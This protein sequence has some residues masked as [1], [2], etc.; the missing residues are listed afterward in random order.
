MSKLSVLVAGGVGYVL[1]ARAG[2]QR[3]E[4]IRS[5]ALRVKGN[6]TVQHTASTAAGAA[7]DAAKHAAP[8]VKDTVTG[9]AGAAVS[10]VK[11]SDSPEVPLEDSAY[12]HGAPPPGSHP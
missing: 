8:V 6:P 10:K 4:Q 7:K 3:Y 9:V 12:P 5:A 2:R 1:G 11:K